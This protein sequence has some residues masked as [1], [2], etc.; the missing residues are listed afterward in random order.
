MVTLS[1]APNLGKAYV[2][3]EPESEAV[4]VPTD[5]E[6]RRRSAK[7]RL[8]TK[9]TEKVEEKAAETEVEETAGNGTGRAEVLERCRYWPNCKRG[10]SCPYHHPTVPCKL[11]PDCKYGKKC[12]YVHP[13][14]KYN[15]RYCKYMQKIRTCMCAWFLPHC[16][17]SS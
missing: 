14:C 8:G 16:M 5:E 13:Q 6:S 17:V 4:P 12:L 15:S 7:D 11:F 3:A 9:V 1:G 10:D 2:S